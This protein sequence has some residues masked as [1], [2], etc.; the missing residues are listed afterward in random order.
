VIQLFVLSL[1]D[2]SILLTNMNTRTKPV[3]FGVYTL[4]EER[5]TWSS[6]DLICE[7]LE[8]CAPLQFLFYMCDLCVGWVSASHNGNFSRYYQVNFGNLTLV[9]AIELSSSTEP[10]ASAVAQYLLRYSNDGINWIT[11]ETVSTTFL[12]EMR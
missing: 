10:T 8:T 2:Y 9:T 12:R 3:H 6:K 5:T 11:G 1:E 4:T 7:T